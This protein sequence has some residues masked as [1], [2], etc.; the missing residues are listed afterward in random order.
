MNTDLIIAGLQ[1]VAI[2]AVLTEP[3]VEGVKLAA[4]P[5][6]LSASQKQAVSFAVG[7]AIAAATGTTLFEG[8]IA[9]MIVGT[10]VAGILAGRGGNIVHSLIGII[11]G[12]ADNLQV[13]KIK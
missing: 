11:K 12:A 6:E 5:R 9:A 10:L 13:K 1:Q 8:N 4:L 2:V 7:T 3:I